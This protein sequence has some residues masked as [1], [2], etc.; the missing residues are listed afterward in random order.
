MRTSLA[1]AISEELENLHP[2]L[3]LA[4]LFVAA[5]PRLCFSRLRTAIYRLAG[6]QIGPRTTVLGRLTIT[7]PGPQ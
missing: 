5:L 7:G 3:I 2:A 1:R 6:I 4:D